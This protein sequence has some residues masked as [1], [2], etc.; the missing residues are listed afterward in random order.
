M[1][2]HVLIGAILLIGLGYCFLPQAIDRLGPQ[3]DETRQNA[4]TPTGIDPRSTPR[5]NPGAVKI[6]SLT[7]QGLFVDRFQLTDGLYELNWDWAHG[8]RVKPNADNLPRLTLLYVHGWKHDASPVDSDLVHFTEL[9]QTLQKK[10]ERQKQVLGIYVSWNALSGFG[11]LDNLTFWSKKFIADRIAQSA[12]VTKIIAAVGALRKIDDQRI[13]QF[14][15]MGHSFGARIVFSATSQSMIAD[16]QLA[17]PLRGEEYRKMSGLADA[18]ILLNPAFEAS[19]YTALDAVCRE[20]KGFPPDQPPLLVS[21]ATDNDI[22]TGE[23]FPLGQWLGIHR[24]RL[25]KSTL[26]NYVPYRTHSLAAAQCGTGAT[27]VTDKF[28]AAGLCLSRNPWT[29][30]DEK[31]HKTR[32]FGN[33]FLVAGTTKEIIDGHNGIWNEPFSDW[34]SAFI[35]E[36][37][38]EHIEF[39]ERHKEL[40]NR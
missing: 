18:V 29:I 9:I 2:R 3:A 24:T 10:F 39:L 35:T 38:F 22:A 34:L 5:P 40:L 31:N 21:I 13:D 37:Q 17:Y 7:D 4:C 20:E 6:I 1:R 19:L 30:D 33:P 26:G 27:A 32:C 8:P 36:L 28:Q 25:E 14:I 16:T 23:Y 15:V 12:V 11:F